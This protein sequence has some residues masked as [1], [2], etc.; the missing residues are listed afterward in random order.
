MSENIKVCIRFRPLNSRELRQ[1]HEQPWIWNR[2]LVTPQFATSR[3]DI[4]KDT[5]VIPPTFAFDRVFDSEESTEQLYLE[6]VYDLVVSAMQ[7][8]HASAMAYGQTSTGK[9]FTMQGSADIP[10]VIPRSIHDIFDYVKGNKERE[11]LLRVSYLEVYNESVND[12]FS[13]ASSNLRIY[14][15]A[16]QGPMVQGLE[17]KIVVSPEQIFALI[18]AGESQ[19]HIGSTDFNQHSSRSHSIV[20]VV[21]ESKLRDSTGKAQ[22][23]ILNL[24]D[25]A[26][27]ECA[28]VSSDTS[29]RNE[30]AFINKSLLTLTSIIFKLSERNK[31]NHIPYRDSKLTR[32]LAKSLQ[33]NSRISIICCV[34]PFFGAKEETLN[35]IRFATRAKKVIHTAHVNEVEDQTALLLKYKQEIEDLKL[36]LKNA[37]NQI[38]MSPKQRGDDVIV[39]DQIDTAIKNLNRVILNSNMAPSDSTDKKN[40]TTRSI[41]P[42]QPP[43][44]ESDTFFY[45]PRRS[46]SFTFKYNPPKV[47]SVTKEL[48]SIREQLSSLL[49]DQNNLPTPVA[50]VKT[51][52][53][54]T[55]FQGRIAELEAIIRQHNLERS[56]ITADH[57]FLQKLLAEKEGMIAEWNVAIE[58]IELKQ[59]LLDEENTRLKHLLYGEVPTKP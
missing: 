28:A 44:F 50:G 55:D 6:M 14:E 20:R 40:S 48:R 13:P 19:R 34:T 58:A 23:S 22:V 17:E 4:G 36:K 24:V 25:L 9:T 18:A 29:R 3:G 21:I 5:A 43:D 52:V 1:G 7:G 54:P 41:S 47:S 12:L 16:K 15:D 39:R 59:K 27:S 53:A 57:A 56:V 38:E 26:G 35:T 2:Q 37:E 8:K 32:I 42:I 31:P 46:N 11:F 51:V 33:G 10:G 49:K 45:S 30:G